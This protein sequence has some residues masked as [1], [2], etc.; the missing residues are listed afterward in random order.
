MGVSSV[1]IDVILFVYVYMCLRVY[2]LYNDVCTLVM[3][4]M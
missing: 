3:S 1:C 2:V 4:N